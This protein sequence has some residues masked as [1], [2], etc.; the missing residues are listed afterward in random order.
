LQLIRVPSVDRGHLTV[1]LDPGDREHSLH[2]ACA[3]TS[4]GEEPAVRSGG[5]HPMQ[6]RAVSPP[7][8][9]MSDDDYVKFKNDLGLAPIDRSGSW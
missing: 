2:S 4:L 9:T 7:V 5:E 6:D 3:R 1:E 8:Q